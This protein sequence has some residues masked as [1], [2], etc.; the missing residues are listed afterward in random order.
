MKAEQMFKKLGYMKMVA[1]DGVFF[2]YERPSDI[3][4]YFLNAS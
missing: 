2:A 1:K 4:G 3:D